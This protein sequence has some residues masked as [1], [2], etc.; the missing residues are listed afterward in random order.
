[1]AGIFRLL[2]H[3]SSPRRL[4]RAGFVLPTTV[5][6]ILM[7]ALTATALTYR[8][9]SRSE[10]VIA[11]REQ[12]VIENAATPAID[13][14][15]AKLEFLF[16]QDE[17][18]PSGLPSSDILVDMM[19]APG[20][21][22]TGRMTA[23][24]GAPD[25]YT[26]PDEERIDINSNVDSALDN[27]WMFK[28]D[29][30][31]DGTVS[32]D[33]IV[34]Y[35]ILAD[36]QGPQENT[37]YG[38]TDTPDQDKAEA[39][40]TR[41][42]P[43]STSEATAA[44]QGA[45]SEGGWQEVQA[46]GT[47]MLQKNFQVVAFVANRNE[48]NRTIQTLE[49][50]QSRQAAK[51]SKWGVWYRYD[52]E[53]HPGADFNF[54]GAMHTEG[55][56]FLGG[57]PGD[58]FDSFMVSSDESCIYSKEASE[59]TVGPESEDGSFQG[60]VVSG[61][62]QNNDDNE[63]KFDLWEGAGT[64]PTT[65][66]ELDEDND[67]V[68]EDVD[69]DLA[70]EIAMDP[71]VLFTRGERK[72]INPSSWTR[73][74]D[75]D[76]PATNEFL[77]KER[78]L[79]KASTAPFVD[80]FYRADDRW[81]PKPRF[82]RAGTRLTDIGAKVGQD[83]TGRDEMI[84]P[85]TGL[86]GF[87]ERQAIDKGMR[88][89]MGQRLELGNTFGW[90]VV[91][92]SVGNDADGD[93]VLSAA[94]GDTIDGTA[95][96]YSVSTYNLADSEVLDN[97]DPLYPPEITEGVD[98]S[99]QGGPHEVMQRRSLRDN[100]AAVQ[101][102]T[103]YHY[104]INNGEFPAAC[105]AMTAHPGTPQTI[106]NSRTFELAGLDEDDDG[107]KDVF[108]DSD[109]DSVND[110]ALNF[111]EGRGTN[112]WEASYNSSFDTESEFITAIGSG[113]PLGRALRNLA[114]FA[115]DPNGGAPSFQPVQDSYVHPYPWMAMWGDFSALRRILDSGT[116]YSDLSWA[117]KATLHSAACTLSL[118]AYSTDQQQ[119]L[120]TAVLSDSGL[121]WNN[122]GTKIVGL[123][124]SNTINSGNPI[125]GRP[126]PTD[127][128]YAGPNLCNALS[129]GTNDTIPNFANPNWQG[130]PVRN[131][132]TVTN[133]D[134][135]DST[136]NYFSYF[137]TEEWLNAL[138]N[139]GGLDADERAVLE[140]LIEGNQILRDRTLGFAV[141]AAF[142][143][144]ADPAGDF[145]PA[146][147]V[148]TNPADASAKVESG[149]VDEGDK[150]TLGCDPS[151]FE[152]D[153]GSSGIDASSSSKKA[154]LG[155]ALVTCSTQ[156][157][158]KY[159]ALYYLFP[160][161]SHDHDGDDGSSDTYADD[162]P[163]GEE[164]ISKLNTYDATPG[165]SDPVNSGVTYEPI[166]S[167]DADD[168]SDI[169]A[170]PHKA[171]L[172]DWVL[173]TSSLSSAGANLLDDPDLSPSQ[174]FRIVVGGSQTGTGDDRTFDVSLLDKG[175]ANVREQLGVRVLD[176]DMAKLTQN[177]ASGS[178]NSGGDYWISANSENGAEGIVYA[179]R[180][181][182]VAEDEIVRPYN[183]SF[184]DAA[185]AWTTC[186]SFGG[187]TGTA[188][189]QME[190]DPDDADSDSVTAQDPP[191]ND[192]NLISAKPV[193][194]YP[195]PERRPHGFRL[196]RGKDLSGPDMTDTN[197]RDVGFTLVTSD[198][199]YIQGDFN[200]HSDDGST[201]NLEEFDN[202]LDL[203][204]WGDFYTRTAT[205]LDTDN[206]ATLTEDHW[207]PTE[208]LSDGLN[209]LSANF[210]D[211]SIL[212]TFTAQTVSD[213]NSTPTTGS[214]S[215][216]SLHR[217]EFYSDLIESGESGSDVYTRER[218]I[219][220]GEWLGIDDPAHPVRI[221]RNGK[222]EVVRNDGNNGWGGV[223]DFIEVSETNQIR[224]NLPDAAETRINA[225]FV[226]NVIPSRKG[227]FNG[228]LHNYPRML[229]HWQDTQLFIS[230]AFLQLDFSRAATGPFDPD[231][232][233]EP[234]TSEASTT[235]NYI[236]YY[237]PPDRRWGYDVGLLYVPAGPVARR[238]VDVED[239]RSEYYREL[240]ADDA[241]IKL[242]QCAK[243]KDGNRII[244]DASCS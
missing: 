151:S 132:N 11:E 183:S 67:S 45:V 171:D 50:Q 15:K 19:L 21:M 226:S 22:Y 125:I 76:D 114:N 35:A 156:M 91:P 104:L 98:G 69:A 194:F 195:D 201:E 117:D 52:L 240:P 228:G 192:S 237:M 103:V 31:N 182:A 218:W 64:D 149:E 193:D 242:L 220:E 107:T 147:G 216:R 3:W 177:E 235:D 162:Q 135:P 190:V 81:G 150:Y 29:I 121:N 196:K 212:D 115:G 146:T 96:A 118:L 225:L 124:D 133:E 102:M 33:E 7:L 223:L 206:F 66:V 153:D 43:Q 27:A 37:T 163:T 5:L 57:K 122:L 49:F 202:L 232:R 219:Q 100:L 108:V 167:S 38:L 205:E 17:R 56:A 116:S 166:D 134:D 233:W 53:V 113:Q 105:L 161:E 123:I 44:C 230:G 109:G 155:L 197:R 26:L 231:N 28:T 20:D 148:W 40:V 39:L 229:E 10:A 85:V 159:P 71:I 94:A 172:S 90:N 210:K 80:D 87:W 127:E 63:A 32:D 83:I 79:N 203:P 4:S 126:K 215:Y 97:S 78:I 92:T 34:V 170:V 174:D 139:S 8:S 95:D 140:F 93:G 42:G 16:Q 112:G 184:A 1:M 168:V 60:Q 129:D 198:S 59:I 213:S 138:E 145:D 84:N 128:N 58:G 106:I 47:A 191:L 120:V 25:P 48:V 208:I 99:Q 165:G 130:C 62:L 180:E 72:H 222:Y 68:S 61:R 143:G 70:G 239:I 221:D 75:W 152:S 89:I 178:F 158:P 144:D 157:Q 224:S 74:A 136:K 65:G 2:W 175:I 101:G 12:Q 188:S 88:I 13:R 77:E 173:P 137:S 236:Y 111:F 204:D 119:Q 73:D 141:D 142:T 51:A 209:V 185:T 160:R 23:L 169:A 207:R 14:A 199:V 217:P 41:T 244:P 24:P 243:D 179:F 6:L 164:Y 86:D 9:F 211:G 200:L 189:C 154:K 176:I 54:N 238:F 30:D 110:L 55:T 234:S 82:G 186:G 131:P 181:D 18:F 214:T 241:Y 187:L 46:G 36:D 227:Q